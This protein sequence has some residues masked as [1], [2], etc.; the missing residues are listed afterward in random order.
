MRPFTL[1]RQAQND[2]F[3]AALRTTGN[4]RLAARLLG[5][6][7]ST[8]TKRRARCPA[9]AAAW[10]AALAAA[11]RSLARL[12]AADPPTVSTPA[13]APAT[14]RLR[15]V[16][17]EPHLVRTRAGRLQRRAAPPGRITAAGLGRALAIVERTNNLSIAAAA[18]GCA[19]PTLVALARRSPLFAQALRI[20]R[21]C[22]AASIREA[23]RHAAAEVRARPIVV[24]EPVEWIEG[25]TLEDAFLILQ[26]QRAREE[27]RPP[28][29]GR[30]ALGRAIEATTLEDVAAAIEASKIRLARAARFAAEG[31]WRLPAEPAPPYPAAGPAAAAPPPP[32]PDAKPARRRRGGAGGRREQSR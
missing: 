3:L 30:A 4:A 21:A 29:Q 15:T 28:G 22:G 19:L 27:G 20:A 31:T 1:R 17:G 8:Y 7:R 13:G 2:A 14:A 26:H 23:D 16:G 6:H 12:S 25:M 5:V 10:D 18:L 11:D 32:D 24:W 9:F